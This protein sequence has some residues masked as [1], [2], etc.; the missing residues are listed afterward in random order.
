MDG[1][2]D[3][4]TA[5]ARCSFVAGYSVVVAIRITRPA[6]VTT[7]VSTYTGLRPTSVIV[8]DTANSH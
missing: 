8:V 5:S 2:N 1:D 7:P 4:D 6:G 3:T